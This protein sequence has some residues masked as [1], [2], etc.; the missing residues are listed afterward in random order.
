M[1]DNTLA[2]IALDR[3]DNFGE[4][5]PS[6]V[7]GRRDMRL[8]RVE[9]QRTITVFQI[10]KSVE[11]LLEPKAFKVRARIGSI[12]REMKSKAGAEDC[13]PLQRTGDLTFCMYDAVGACVEP[14]RL[15]VWA[16]NGRA[17][18]N[19]DETI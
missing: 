19:G 6:S 7:I 11:R 17:Q 4:L 13:I 9:S 12:V 14:L 10:A 18:K 3:L 5:N 16:P 1:E 15:Q 8:E 2:R